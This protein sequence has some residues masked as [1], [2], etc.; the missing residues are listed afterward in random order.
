MDRW[1]DATL[2]ALYELANTLP[3]PQDRAVAWIAWRRLAW[4]A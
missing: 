1:I 4:R 3:D 2:E